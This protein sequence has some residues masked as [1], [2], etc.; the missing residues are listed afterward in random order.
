MHQAP[1]HKLTIVIPALNEEGAIASTISRCLT[2]REEIK[3]ATDL[4]VEIIVVSDGSTDRTVEIASEFEAV[5]LIVFEEN[6][7]YGAAIKEG[8]ARGTGELVGFLD[9][10]GTC[11]PTYFVGMCRAA[12][13]DRADVVLGSRMGPDSKM[14]RVRRLGNRLFALLLGGL[15]GRQVTDTA[16]GMRVIRRDV[17]DL[18]YP[19]PDRLHFTPAMSARALLNDLRV[20]EIPMRYE[21]RVGTSK[22][23]VV[24]DGFRFLRSILDGVLC[25]RPERPFFLLFTMFLL[26]GTLLGIAP[27]E[28]Y[29]NQRR[30]EEWMIY[31]FLACFLLGA[32]GFLLL[33]AAVLANRMADLGPRR[34]GTESFWVSL[35]SLL[36]RGKALAAFVVA[37]VGIS[38]ALIFPGAVEFATTGGITLHWS[39]I[40]VGAFGFLVAFQALTTK[41]LMEAVSIW[42]Y[43]KD[44]AT[45]RVAATTSPASAIGLGLPSLQVQGGGR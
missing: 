40:I 45:P 10:D 1:F 6:R 35:A 7:G 17:L 38:T 24:N 5:D 39:R 8:F 32:V 34:R 23:Q 9:A 25:F 41:V 33:C 31:R 37:A 22:L 28:H 20:V 26:M 29:W 15:C 42:Q 4:D 21:E 14:P 18:L 30:V 27:T 16:S 36:F 2:A 3:L 11:D 12:L 19:L 44:Q 43:Q 13:D